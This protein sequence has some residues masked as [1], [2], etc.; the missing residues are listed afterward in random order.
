MSDESLQQKY[1]Y[2]LA[3]SWGTEFWCAYALFAVDV[4]RGLATEEEF[5]DLTTSQEIKDRVKVLY[6]QLK[7]T[8]ESINVAI[9][10]TTRA[11]V[12]QMKADKVNVEVI[13][14]VLGH[15]MN[16][17]PG[18]IVIDQ[19]NQLWTELDNYLQLE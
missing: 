8:N 18:D 4:Q 2:E 7:K 10:A 19:L 9:V 5:D 6:H 3:M 12:E 11:S 14:E 17:H 13:K 16:R 1:D 15:V